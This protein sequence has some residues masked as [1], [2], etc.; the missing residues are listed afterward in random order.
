VIYNFPRTKFVDTTSMYDQLMHVKSEVEEMIEAYSDPDIEVF[1]GEV[2]DGLHSL[3]TLMRK[4]QETRGVSP[5]KVRR[6][7]EQKNALRLY[8]SL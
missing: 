4:L 3:E 7:T 1:A 2:M 8:Y 6:D 5:S